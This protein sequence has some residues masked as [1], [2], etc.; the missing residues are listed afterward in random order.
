[1]HACMPKWTSTRH[2]PGDRDLCAGKQHTPAPADYQPRYVWWES[3]VM[4]RKLAIAVITVFVSSGSGSSSGSSVS[5]DTMLGVQ[6]L[7]VVCVLVLALVG[8]STGAD[9]RSCATCPY[10]LQSASLAGASFNTYTDGCLVRCPN[11]GGAHAHHQQL[12]RP[13]CLP[14][15]RR[16]SCC[17]GHIITR[18]HQLTGDAVPQCAALHA[19]LQLAAHVRVRTIP[20]Q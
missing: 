10:C 6:L 19:V 7:L 11:R 20:M 15:C 1:M 16:P 4:L 18:L 14:S 12:R 8:A 2:G 17:A 9:A 5:M 3:L 13:L